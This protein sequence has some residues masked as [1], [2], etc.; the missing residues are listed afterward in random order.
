MDGSFLHFLTIFLPFFGRILDPSHQKTAVSGRQN[1]I[2]LA[3]KLCKALSRL[4]VPKHCNRFTPFD[5]IIRVD[6]NIGRR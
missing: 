6:H 2:D 4:C 1:E 3:E 5:S